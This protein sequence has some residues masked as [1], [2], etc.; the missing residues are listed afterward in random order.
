MID[1]CADYIELMKSIF[2]FDQIKALVG[3]EGKLKV[4]L[5]RFKGGGKG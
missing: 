5:D 2:N 1:P 4:K 3:G